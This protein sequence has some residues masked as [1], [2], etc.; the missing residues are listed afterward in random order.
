[1]KLITAATSVRPH[2]ASPTPEALRNANSSRSD[3][4]VFSDIFLGP[5]VCEIEIE[6]GQHDHREQQDIGE[7]RRFT[8]LHILEGDAIDV[9]G[10]RFGGGAGTAFGQ[11]KHYIEELERL[12]G[13]KQERQH[14]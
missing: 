4:E 9:Y 13:A 6:V 14:Q 5:P 2:P 3:C 11:E 7:R 12:D 1:M 10:D 8:C